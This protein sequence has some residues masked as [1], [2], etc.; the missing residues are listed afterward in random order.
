MKWFKH[1][2]NAHTD[3]KL[4]KLRH[5]HGIEGYGL[6]WYCLE[7]IAGKV[8]KSNITFELEDDA[9]TI[10]R[11]WNMDQIKVQEIMQYMCDLRLFSSNNGT[12]SCLKLAKRLDDT[13]AKNPEIKAI[14]DLLSRTHSEEL[15]EIPNESDQI[16]LDQTRSEEKENKPSGDGRFDEFYAAYPKKVKR[17]P[18][19]AIWKRK[20]LDR[21][22][23]QIIQ[24]VAMRLSSDRRWLDGFVPD[25]TTYLNQE[26]WN[27]EMQRGDKH[28]KTQQP[29]DTR[30][31]LQ[32]FEDDL[33]AGKLG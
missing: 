5:R 4:K 14:I 17:K 20:K 31:A 2:S 13:N 21:I 3:T 6:Y 19:L 24:D 23:D 30:T 29:R 27:D 15:G 22:A 12:I 8:D 9:Q 33:A 18:A 25:P 1:D 7:L 11:D 10:A 32:R 28:A 16:R 26:R